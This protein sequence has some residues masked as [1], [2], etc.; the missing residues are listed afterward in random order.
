MEKALILS[1]IWAKFLGIRRK[2][3][4][5]VQGDLEFHEVRVLKDGLVIP[6]N[7]E[8]KA[9]INNNFDTIRIILG[10]TPMLEQL[11]KWVQQEQ[12]IEAILHEML[13]IKNPLWDEEKVR[14]ESA[15]IIGKF[16]EDKLEPSVQKAILRTLAP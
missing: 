6:E 4:E 1:K 12:F 2:S 9:I 14:D 13:H 15:E 8:K 3:I 5:V 10:K 7:L 11:P 16:M